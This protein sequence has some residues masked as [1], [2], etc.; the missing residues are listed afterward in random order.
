MTI[1]FDVGDQTLPLLRQILGLLETLP[2]SWQDSFT[3]F[4]GDVD[5]MV[6]RVTGD[7]D[8]L[9][10]QVATLQSQLSSADIPADAQATLDAID[11]KINSL[12]VAAPTPPPTPAPDQ[13]P[14]PAPTPG[15]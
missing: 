8:T 1:I 6:T 3:K 10:A 11:S 14:A 2:M 13:P 12:D 4:S 15:T 7:I 5:A 9:K